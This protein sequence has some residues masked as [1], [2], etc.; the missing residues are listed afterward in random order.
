ME[1]MY[2][3]E[4]YENT[5]TQADNKIKDLEDEMVELHLAF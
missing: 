4:H 5:M 3:I 2:N 1:L